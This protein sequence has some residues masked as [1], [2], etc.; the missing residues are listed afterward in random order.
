MRQFIV[1]WGNES[2]FPLSGQLH[3]RK[4]EGGSSPV[5]GDLIYVM[6]NYADSSRVL[7]RLICTDAAVSSDLQRLTLSFQ[8]PDSAVFFRKPSSALS[9][10]PKFQVPK[11]REITSCPPDL[12]EWLKSAIGPNSFS[13]PYLPI[14]WASIVLSIKQEVDRANLQSD[15]RTSVQVASD[16]LKRNY[17]TSELPGPAPVYRNAARFALDE[18]LIDE[19]RPKIG[20]EPTVES[21][22][23]RRRQSLDELAINNAPADSDAYF[24][25]PPDSRNHQ[26][27]LG[28]LRDTLV[29]IG[30]E[31]LHDGYVDCIVELSQFDVFFEVKSAAS[32]VS[33]THQ[34]RQAVGQLLYYMWLSRNQPRR[35]AGWIVIE[36][37]DVDY[38]FRSYVSSVGL[39]VVTTNDL[40]SLSIAKLLHSKFT[41]SNQVPLKIDNR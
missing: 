23:H 5:A 17:P 38:D 31:P 8:H 6:A 16:F 35:V 34:L 19:M 26:A 14:N 30:L 24:T 12:H 41:T 3:L 32:T 29:A 9:C 2:D 1:G 11:D 15:T 10:P 40:K 36:H 27:I 4:P 7:G 22:T 28:K 25:R 21:A 13:N 39:T 37:Q 20:T 33:F 18:S